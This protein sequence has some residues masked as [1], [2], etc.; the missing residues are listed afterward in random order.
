MRLRPRG[1]VGHL[2]GAGRVGHTGLREV[3]LGG[4]GPVFLRLRRS[5]ER[6]RGGLRWLCPSPH[7]HR[8]PLGP[9]QMPKAQGSGAPRGSGG[10]CKPS[11][12]LPSRAPFQGLGV[13]NTQA[14]CQWPGACLFSRVSSHSIGTAEA[15]GP[16]TGAGIFLRLPSLPLLL[17]LTVDSGVPEGRKVRT[18]K[19]T[20]T[21]PLDRPSQPAT[22]CCQHRFW[23]QTT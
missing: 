19:K 4:H 8:S 2:A 17:H 6:G 3:P 22:R 12:E 1:Q 15:A 14:P 7:A 10:Q 16:P 13:K 23:R 18:P 11:R 9:P 20:V 5:C 21:A